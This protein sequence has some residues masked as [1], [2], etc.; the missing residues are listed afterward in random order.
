MRLL[1]STIGC[2]WMVF[3][4]GARLLA[5]SETSISCRCT[6][7]MR[8]FTF[9]ASPCELVYVAWWKKQVR[10]RMFAGSCV[11]GS[12]AVTCW[13]PIVIGVGA[14]VGCAGGEMPGSA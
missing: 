14:I 12:A 9:A 10:D 11:H 5:T 2:V 1:L 4:H 3:K 7:P 6:A 8:R 13:P